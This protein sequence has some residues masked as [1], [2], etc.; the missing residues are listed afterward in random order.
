MKLH[1][2][3][4]SC[5]CIT[6]NRTAL[7][8]RA[9]Y[10]FAFQNYPNKELVISYPKSDVS[11]KELLSYITM[12]S[13]LSILP[14]ERNEGLSVGNARNFAITKCS[15]DYVCIWDDDDWYHAS[16]LSFQFN[17]MVT[18]ENRY[19]A[20]VLTQFFLFDE[21]MSRA[22]LSFQ[23]CWE[24]TLLCRK[25]LLLQNQYANLNRGEDSHIIRFLEG[26][27]FL[28]YIQDAPFLYV[29]IFHGANTWSYEHF[30]YLMNRS[31]LLDE[32]YSTDLYKLINEYNFLI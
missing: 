6:N 8:K 14:V 4:I 23:H 31:E 21:T 27:K 24:N 10:C 9:I 19:N 32:Q 5:I 11:T 13:E 1:H 22:Y 18:S 25:E 20:T 28:Q 26:K 17:S 12:H 2:P 16:R 3:L 29:Y 30:K 15:G 7:L